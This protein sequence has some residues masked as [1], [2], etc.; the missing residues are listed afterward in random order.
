[1]QAS[2]LGTLEMKGPVLGAK[3]PPKPIQ[4]K[5]RTPVVTCSV[6]GQGR[7]ARAFHSQRVGAARFSGGHTNP[8]GQRVPQGHEC[9][10]AGGLQGVV[11]VRR[12]EKK[13]ASVGAGPVHALVPLQRDK[14]LFRDAELASTEH[15]RPLRRCVKGPQVVF[16][17]QRPL[18]QIDSPRVAPTCK[19][20]KVW[21]WAC[22]QLN[23][24]DITPT[25]VNTL[26][27]SFFFMAGKPLN[28]AWWPHHRQ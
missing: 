26:Q 1:M 8:R 24:H 13:L 2:S 27:P 9:P 21:V 23:A 4:F 6:Q 15:I 7:S 11:A 17:R 19:E 20:S 14:V 16:F 22:A 3:W 12:T 10:L 5:R 25:H 28:F 18:F